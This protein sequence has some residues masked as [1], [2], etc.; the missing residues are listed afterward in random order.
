M[1]LIPTDV[2]SD[3]EGKL[4]NAQLCVYYCCA[5]DA[6]VS[7]RFIAMPLYRTRC[8]GYQ[9]Y[10][11]DVK[12]FFHWALNFYHSALSIKQVDPFQSTDADG[13]YPAGDP[14]NVYPGENG[15]IKSTRLVVFKEALQ[16]LRAF[17]LLEQYVGRESV[18]KML[19]E[20]TGEITFENCARSASVI[21]TIRE[22][23]REQLS[24]YIH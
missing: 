17:K 4:G 8:F 22:R 19:E 24:R 10:K 14:F 12:A 2:M 11:Y 23:L 16:D 1:P 6:L 20:I 7:N 18:I 21:L 15:P 13:C 3:F 5:Q 9:L